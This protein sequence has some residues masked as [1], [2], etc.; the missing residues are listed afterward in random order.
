MI[1]EIERMRNNELAWWIKEEGPQR[2]KDEQGQKDRRVNMHGLR[3]NVAIV[4]T[5][6]NKINNAEKDERHLLGTHR[7][8]H[9]SKRFPLH[10]PHV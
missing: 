2:L 4:F 8:R 10:E 3:N 9:Y 7:I 5:K 6:N 1:L